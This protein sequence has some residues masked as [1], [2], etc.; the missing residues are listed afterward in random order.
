MESLAKN[1]WMVVVRGVLALIFGLL[2]FSRPWA[3]LAALVTFFGLYAIFDGFFAL[4]S[5]VRAA[6]GQRP[7]VAL[8]LEGITGLVIGVI[9]L[10]SPGSAAVA[11]L[12]LVSAWAIITGAM[13]LSA[14]V[15]LRQ[16]IEGEWLLG[17]A[18]VLSVLLGVLMLAWP[19]AGMLGLVYLLGAYA[20]AFG[21]TLITL[22]I[23][24]RRLMPAAA[25]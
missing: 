16:E 2:C 20:L 18:G 17:L 21:A 4:I 19:R 9:A 7:W 23:K 25:T 3:G 22:G 10:V 6:A 1:W 24:L 12:V 13:E 14:A 11:M 8:V 5:A 15:R